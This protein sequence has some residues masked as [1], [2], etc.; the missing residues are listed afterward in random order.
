MVVNI[1]KEI[2]NAKI[3]IERARLNIS[4]R[5]LAEKVKTSREKINAIENAK[6]KKV[7]YELLEKIANVF[8]VQI[9]ELLKKE[10]R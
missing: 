9:N 8:N 2:D 4:Q 7:K 5:E 10:E 6:C 1:S 3:R